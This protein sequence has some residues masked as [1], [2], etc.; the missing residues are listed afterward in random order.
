VKEKR[1]LS[2][3]ILTENEDIT[4]MNDGLLPKE[5]WR[6]YWQGISL[7]TIAKPM[8]MYDIHRTLDNILPKSSK[9]SFIE[10]GCAPGRNMAYFNKYFSYSVAGIEYV[11]EAAAA[12]R[13]NMEMQGIHAQ[14][15]NLDFFQA[16]FSPASYDVVFS[17]GFIEHFEDLRGAVN[18]ISFLAKQYVVTI[19]PN[20]YGVNGLI[21]RTIRPKV[22][23]GHKRIDKKHLRH[24]HEESR[25][26]TLYCDYVGGFQFIMP[27][28]KTAFFD[29]NKRLAKTINVPFMIFN[30]MSRTFSRYTN[31]FPRTKFLARSLMYIGEKRDV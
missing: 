22:F 31:L 14:I 19:I 1:M 21:S 27:A 25:L 29:K 10:I 16:A 4:V 7:P 30:V 12:T 28:T 2:E 11:E 6:Q 8:S 26:N 23:Y 9:M 3:S 5:Y 17:C 18:K 15:L 20:C 24:L 13:Q